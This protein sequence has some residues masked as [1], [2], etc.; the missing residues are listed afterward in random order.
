MYAACSIFDEDFSWLT[1]RPSS[2]IFAVHRHPFAYSDIRNLY[3]VLFE[4]YGI[5]KKNINEQKPYT[6]AAWKRIDL[7]GKNVLLLAFYYTHSAISTRTLHVVLNDIIVVINS[8]NDST[9]CC[10]P[11]PRALHVFYENVYII[12]TV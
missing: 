1:S 6:F 11:L 4:M 10:S 7:A 5:N 9:I 3:H 8:H 12:R 2:Q